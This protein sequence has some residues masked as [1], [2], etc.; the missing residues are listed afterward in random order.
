MSNE[1]TDDQMQDLMERQQLKES[2]QQ[3][4]PNPDHA[5]KD[6]LIDVD[7]VKR[8]IRKALIGGEDK[9]VETDDGKVMKV[10]VTPENQDDRLC[11]EKCIQDIFR[12]IEGNVNT[13][14]SGSYLEGKDVFYM[15]AMA[16]HAVSKKLYI[17]QE[18]YEIDGPGDASLIM[19]IVNSNLKAAIRKAYKGRLLKHSEQTRSI[20]E[21]RRSEDG[22][23]SGSGG[24]GFWNKF[25]L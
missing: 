7:E 5:G 10:H 3:Q 22:E 4:D 18:E 19:S 14:V 6:Q 17:N 20:R 1:I 15:G 12:A 21:L 2:I 9:W 25:G 24:N 23:N 16:S 8:Q 13:N 11:N